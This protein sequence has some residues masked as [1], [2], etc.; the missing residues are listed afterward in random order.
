V[1]F[2]LDCLDGCG[3]VASGDS[4]SA[5]GSAVAE[6][7]WSAHRMPVDPAEAGE[8]AVQVDGFVEHSAGE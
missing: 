5:V 4:R 8:L 3:Y 2:R 7:M 6:H 1:N